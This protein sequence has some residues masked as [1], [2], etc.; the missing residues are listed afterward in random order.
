MTQYTLLVIVWIAWCALHSALV[1]LSLTEPLRTRFPH[2]ARY[3]RIVYSTVSVVTLAPVLLY[4]FSLRGTPIFSW[5]GPWRF[6]QI[7]LAG[8][9]LTFF[10]AGA[11]H[12]DLFQFLGL[13]QLRDEKACSVLTDDCSLDTSGILS[14][15]RHPWY[16]G[17]ILII[18]ARPLDTSAILTNLVLTGYFVVGTRLEERKLTAQFGQEYAEY[19]R[20]VSMF[21]PLKWI[22]GRMRKEV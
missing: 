10:I 14:L 3:Y 16:T 18:W 21:L 7:A 1:S 15:V 12:Y 6:G 4:A 2:A 19:Q 9:A 22:A 13:R 11:R 8:M 17:G 5:Q 20:R